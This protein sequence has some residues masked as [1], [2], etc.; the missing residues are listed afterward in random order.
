MEQSKIIDTLE[1]YHFATE[2]R[3]LA[4]DALFMVLSNIA[5]RHPELDLDDG[6]KKPPAGAD[7]GA[8]KE[9]AAPW[10]DRVLHV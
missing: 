9:K 6:F 7:V 10:A 3:K 1:T 4:R 2:S 5:C 8:A